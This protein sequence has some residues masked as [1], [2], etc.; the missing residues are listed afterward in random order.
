M[1]WAVG[2]GGRLIALRMVQGGDAGRESLQYA[3]VT[4]GSGAVAGTRE[5]LMESSAEMAYPIP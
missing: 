4:E 3:A 2:P 5:R 1:W